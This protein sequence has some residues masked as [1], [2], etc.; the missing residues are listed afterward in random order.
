MAQDK[1]Y[2]LK[3]SIRAL[4]GIDSDNTDM[5]GVF[6]LFLKT[7]HPNVNFYKN[8]TAM[9]GIGEID[10]LSEVF[11]KW[12][13]FGETPLV[14]D[15]VFVNSPFIE[16]EKAWG[17]LVEYNTK[18][19]VELLI[20]TSGGVAKI[21]DNVPLEIQCIW[22]PTMET[23]IPEGTPQA[24]YWGPML[25]GLKYLMKNTD[26][27]PDSDEFLDRIL[28][29]RDYLP[30]TVENFKQFLSSTPPHKLI[31]IDDNNIPNV[32]DIVFGEIPGSVGVFLATKMIFGS[33]KNNIYNY[34]WK[35][36]KPKSYWV[37]IS[38]S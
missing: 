23:T 8:A 36:F 2:N 38:N 31:N 32:G 28:R 3:S 24:L 29:G 9:G 19:D 15:L 11:G 25:S 7:L 21:I 5:S 27:S 20:P 34:T 17:I 37:P 35:A 22:S 26:G 33:T 18:T 6:G 12:K 30:K 16:K 13:F 1:D 4:D 14:G 10:S